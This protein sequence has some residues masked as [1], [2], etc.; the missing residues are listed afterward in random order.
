MAADTNQAHGI[1]PNG[2]RPAEPASSL[3]AAHFAPRLTSHGHDAQRLSRETFSQLRQE[4]L[5]DRQS[6]I[7]ADEGITDINKLIC[8]VLKAG[9]EVSPNSNSNSNNPEDEDLEGQ[10]LDCLDIIQASIE[11]A[12]QVL[13]DISDPLIL[14]EDVHAPLFA[15]LILRLIRLASIWQSES[16]QHRIQQV[17]ME[18]S[19]LQ[20]KQVRSSASCYSILAFLR[21]CI[22]GSYTT[23]MVD[24]TWPELTGE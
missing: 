7:R 18:I 11:K 2:Q 4:L 21:A 22:S 1:M 13:W 8:I 23:A 12:P 19:C 9:L 3:L 6:Q 17:F 10:I 20:Y 14:G 15:W 24:S 5:G 16:V